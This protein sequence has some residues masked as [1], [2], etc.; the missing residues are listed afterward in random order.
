MCKTNR[1]KVFRRRRRGG[2]QGREGGDTAG[3]KC[4]MAVVY[5]LRREGGEEGLGGKNAHPR[6]EVLTS[7]SVSAGPP[8]LNKYLHSTSL[9]PLYP[10]V[11]ECVSAACAC[12]CV[13]VCVCVYRERFW[14][15][16]NTSIYCSPSA[17]PVDSF[18]IFCFICSQCKAY[19]NVSH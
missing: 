15:S 3:K 19:G 8:H 9:F 6:P 13:C 2:A 5:I 17:K 18:S 16:Q 12:V 11:F 10:S 4:P 14:F 1:R 7:E